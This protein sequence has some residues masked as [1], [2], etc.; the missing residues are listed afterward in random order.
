MSESKKD[1]VGGFNIGDYEIEDND[2]YE[3]LI[4]GVVPSAA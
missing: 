3:S 4:E 1:E 2:N